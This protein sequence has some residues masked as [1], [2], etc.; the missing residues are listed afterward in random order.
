MKLLV[1]EEGIDEF[2]ASPGWF[3]RFLKR[4]RLKSRRI[5]TSGKQQLPKDFANIINK[6]LDNV[7]E[8]IDQ[9]SKNKL[10]QIF[11]FEF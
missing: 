11:F 5:T 6:Y 4:F 8:C 2:K 1:I 7:Q 9:K 10:I 3:R